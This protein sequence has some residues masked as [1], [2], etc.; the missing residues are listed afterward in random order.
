MTLIN[1]VRCQEGW[2]VVG[3]GRGH[4]TTASQD[5]GTLH[6]VARTDG[7]VCLGF[8][9]SI[10]QAQH[11]FATQGISSSIRDASGVVDDLS[12]AIKETM[13]MPFIVM[14][15]DD[16]AIYR[17]KTFDAVTYIQ[18]QREYRLNSPIALRCDVP[19][20]IQHPYCNVGAVSAIADW[21]FTR[22][23]QREAPLTSMVAVALAAQKATEAAFS[24]YVGG[25]VRIRASRKNGKEWSAEDEQVAR[26]KADELLAKIHL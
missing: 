12:S 18:E 24:K 3:V 22:L 23:Y 5:V 2:V 13:P 19:E 11:I 7:G 10:G 25:E 4:I 20:R 21:F 17:L 9:N 8:L 15:V 26:T 1:V 6:K 14:A 16:V